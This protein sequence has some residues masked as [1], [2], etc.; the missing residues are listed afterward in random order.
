MM[1]AISPA[2]SA[3]NSGTRATMFQVT[4]KSRRWITSAKEVAI[5]AYEHSPSQYRVPF[6]RTIARLNEGVAWCIARLDQLV[7][8]GDADRVRHFAEES[9]RQ[10]QKL[11]ECASAIINGNTLNQDE[12]D[13]VLRRR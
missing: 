5:E 7:A 9:S 10:L 12:I 6:D 4:T 11:I 8:K 2:F 1:V 3:A 13:Q